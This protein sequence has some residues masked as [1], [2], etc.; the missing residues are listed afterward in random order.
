MNSMKYER[1]I[2]QNIFYGGVTIIQ[3]ILLALGFYLPII[4]INF[5]NCIKI[6][7]IN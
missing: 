5:I 3:H 7:E 1:G 2:N 4:R 6:Y